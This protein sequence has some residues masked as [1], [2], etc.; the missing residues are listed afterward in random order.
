MNELTKKWNAKHEE[1]HQAG[2]AV[3]L[4]PNR[5][6]RA[7]RQAELDRLEDEVNALARELDEARAA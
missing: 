1:L 3:V 4:A 2:K 6:E 5:M 7:N